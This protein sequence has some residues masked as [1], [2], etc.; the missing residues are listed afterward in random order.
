MKIKVLKKA[1]SKIVSSYKVTAR[2]MDGDADGYGDDSTII[3]ESDLKD[4]SNQAE[5][6]SLL[7]TLERCNAAYQDGKGGFDGY[8]EVEGYEK[9]FGYKGEISEY[10]LDHVSGGY[11]DD[12]ISEF[13]GWDVVYYD[14]LGNE[15]PV[16]V[17]FNDEERESIK[18]ASKIDY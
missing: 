3:S 1:N 8:E 6:E 4:E 18:V 5:F 2:F 11:C 12:C 17:I 10:T 16:T 14:S 9:H 7:L 15:F 13:D